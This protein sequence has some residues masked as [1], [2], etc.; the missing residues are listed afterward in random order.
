MRTS[1]LPNTVTYFWS[2]HLGSAR[3]YCMFSR[4]ERDFLVALVRGEGASE[5]SRR[6]LVSEFPNPIYRRKM[7]WGIR[8]KATRAVADWELYLR[9][10][11]VESKVVP[12]SVGSDLPPLATEPLVTLGRRV[13]SLLRAAPR[14]RTA[15]PK[16]GHREEDRR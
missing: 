11:R 4:R 10:A 1:G 15:R 13:R 3:G 14:P 6:D 8:R 16:D 7:L 9:A 12:V 2:R 5:V